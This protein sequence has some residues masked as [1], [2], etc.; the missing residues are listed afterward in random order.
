MSATAIRVG[1]H[2]PTVGWAKCPPDIFTSPLPVNEI[3]GRPIDWEC[4]WEV[5]LELTH[6]GSECE[7]CGYDGQPWMLIGIVPPAPGQMFRNRRAWP[8]K[9]AFAFRCPACDVI[10]TYDRGAEGG[11]WMPL[12]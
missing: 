10:T 8:I 6:V 3:D 12:P 9:R 11:E 5:A 1:T 4:E 2:G 7:C